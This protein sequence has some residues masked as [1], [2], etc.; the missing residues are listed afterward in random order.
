LLQLQLNAEMI[1]S[2]FT[3]VITLQQFIP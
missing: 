3:K 1:S 2:F